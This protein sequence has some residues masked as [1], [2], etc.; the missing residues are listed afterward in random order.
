LLNAINFNENV[1]KTNQCKTGEKEIARL[2]PCE[3]KGN[4]VLRFHL[5]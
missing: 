5:I 1:L 4:M 3:E 2:V